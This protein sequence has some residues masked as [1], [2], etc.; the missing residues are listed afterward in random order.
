MKFG[1]IYGLFFVFLLTL[2]GCYHTLEWENKAAFYSPELEQ[3]EAGLSLTLE[4]SGAARDIDEIKKA[5]ELS[6]SQVGYRLNY[7]P[8]KQ[9]A[10]DYHLKFLIAKHYDGRAS[11][12]FV[13]FPGSLIFAQ[14]WL[15]YGYDITYDVRCTLIDGKTNKTLE[16]FSIPMKFNVRHA[17]LGRTWACTWPFFIGA[18]P[19]G[20]YCTQYDDDV[21]PQLIDKIFP[22]IGDS[23]A[24]QIVAHINTYAREQPSASAP[25]KP[26]ATSTV[27]PK[28]T[29]TPSSTVRPKVTAPAKSTTTPS[30]PVAKASPASEGAKMEAMKSKL[31]PATDLASRKESLKQRK[32]ANEGDKTP[33][34]EE[35]KAPTK[36]E[37][38]PKVEE[39]PKVEAKPKAEVKDVV[40]ESEILAL[41]EMYEMGAISK[42][43]L[44]ARTKALQKK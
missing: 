44:D 24:A 19:N 25:A 29:Q 39:K 14:G 1:W 27:K 20:F 13:S 15:G 4:M 35:A 38:K 16:R 6:L 43:E 9:A 42:D 17:D 7:G 32:M 31:A 23:V 26:T 10:A 11:N 28:S 33:V 2:T 41:Q 22:A 21:T 12:F 18:I 36:A 5:I 8:K 40:L 37:A 30:K 34:K 3:T